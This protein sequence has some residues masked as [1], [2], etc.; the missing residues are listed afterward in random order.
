MLVGPGTLGSLSW[1]IFFSNLPVKY[2]Q[3]NAACVQ[4]QYSFRRARNIPNRKFF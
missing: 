4:C 3:E 1:T 2:N